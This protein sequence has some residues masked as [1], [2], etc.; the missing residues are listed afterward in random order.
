MAQC[1]MCGHE[2]KLIK[3]HVIPKVFYPLSGS[4]KI[5]SA[6]PSM[7]PRKA[8]IGVYDEGLLCAECDGALGIYDQAFAEQLLKQSGEVVPSTE[9][10][11]KIY[12]VK[13]A[14]II[15]KF[16]L[17]V[18]WRAHHSSH[19]MFRSVNLGPY[20]DAFKR[21]IKSDQLS[22]TSIVVTE[23]DNPNVPFLSPAPDR[24]ENVRFIRIYA[25]HFSLVIKVDKQRMP[26]ALDA[27]DLKNSHTNSVFTV[28]RKYQGSDEEQAMRE[29][30][31]RTSH[32][33][34]E[35]HKWRKAAT[36]PKDPLSIF[37]ISAL[38]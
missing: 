1:K 3:A 20:A 15:R 10:G 7:F 35:I 30:L 17:S 31:T 8:P 33:I 36:S 19:E 9:G 11:I 12:R 26:S 2:K 27:V 22:D 32:N 37:R 34:A 24:I 29:L 38:T 23:F 16:A 13:S 5:L 21:E 18:A 4:T 6:E 28:V 14:D 25:A